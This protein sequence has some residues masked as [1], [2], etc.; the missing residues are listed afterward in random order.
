VDGHELLL[1]ADRAEEAQCVRAEAD[2]P[3]RRERR[4]AQPGARG[5]RQPLAR[6]PGAEQQEGEQQAGRDLDPDTRDERGSGGAKARAR[7]G[8]ECQRAGE[9]EQDQRVVVRAADGQL[10]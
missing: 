6:A 4:Q 8:G 2:Q 3:H 9:H 1:L 5:H 10:E 7:P